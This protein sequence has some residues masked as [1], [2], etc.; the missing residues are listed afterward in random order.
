MITVDSATA[1]CLPRVKLAVSGPEGKRGLNKEAT[2][3][4]DCLDTH[5]CLSLCVHDVEFRFTHTN[6][7][8]PLGCSHT[9]ARVQVLVVTD[10]RKPFLSLPLPASAMTVW[11]C[12]VFSIRSLVCVLFPGPFIGVS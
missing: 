8:L 12:P 10:F 7:S 1:G 2:R 6:L 4:R 5:V 3:L 9:E 11:F